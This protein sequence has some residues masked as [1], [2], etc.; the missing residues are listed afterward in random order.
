MAWPKRDTLPGEHRAKIGEAARARYASGA[1]NPMAG[2][3]H[4]T[5]TRALMAERRRIWWR[6][7]R[8]K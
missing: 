7:R 6:A 5:A 2:R 1:S 4:T 8:K 3:K